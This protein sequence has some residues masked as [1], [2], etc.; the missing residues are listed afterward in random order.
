[1]SPPFLG[2]PAVFWTRRFS[3][4]ALGVGFPGP[5]NRVPILRGWEPPSGLGA[6]A[7]LVGDWPPLLTVPRPGPGKVLI[8][9]F[10]GFVSHGVGL[11]K[12]LEPFLGDF[13]R[14]RMS[15]GPMRVG[16]HVQNL[17]GILNKAQNLKHSAKSQRDENRVQVQ[18]E[19]QADCF[20]G[21]WANRAERRFNMLEEG[22]IEEALNTASA[23]GD[24]TLQKRAQG[25]VVPD[26]FTHGSS[27]D[28]VYWF[29][30]GFDTGDVRECNTI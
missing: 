26:S 11:P 17:L 28:R 25:Y 13:G 21:V 5:L 27:K 24:D 16:H 20:A 6:L 2:F 22:D 3:Q 29:K 7:F 19:L 15:L 14:G 9:D 8:W 10:G 12:F 4:G 1:L 23:I 18:V 30:R